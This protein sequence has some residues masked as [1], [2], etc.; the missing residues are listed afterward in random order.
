MASGLAA[1]VPSPRGAIARARRAVNV[2][3][4][5]FALV[6]FAWLQ[7]VT[8]VIEAR[9][10]RGYDGGEYLSMLEEGWDK[11]TANTALRPL[12]VILN[13]PIFRVTGDALASFRLMNYVYVALL[14]LGLCLLFDAYSS[15]QVAKVILVANVFSSIATLKYI[16]YYPV[17][18]DAGAY[19]VLTLATYF[20][21]SG[22]RI[23]AAVSCVAAVLSREFGVAV[24]LFGA[25]RDVRLRISFRKTALTYLPAVVVLVVWRLVVASHLN[26]SEDEFVTMARLLASL[27]YWNQPVFVAF[28]LYFLL[29][30]F[31]GVSLFVIAKCGFVLRH[32]RSEPEWALFIMAIIAPAALG[33]ADIW[34]YLAYL[35]PAVAVLFA[36]C[37]RE[38]GLL[39]KR[40]AVTA[41]VCAATI[42]TQRPLQVMDLGAYFRDWFPYYVHLQKMPPEV[43]A[44]ELWPLWA[45]RFM[46]AAA[47]LWL[48]GAFPAF[49]QMRIDADRA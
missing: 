44:Q 30:V 26:S 47:L 40:L 46:I 32:L 18:I 2:G 34:R 49:N 15:D 38:I 31:G 33:S 23:P 22:K 37:A 10:G 8:G 21:V 3:L 17:L 43:P 7:S 5:L 36:V 1:S 35:L 14:C 20:I 48:L 11:G 42:L 6:L 27:D 24:L 41:I 29:T 19:A 39:Q 9:G 45:W 12:I 16:A 4:V 25:L 28:F 13:G